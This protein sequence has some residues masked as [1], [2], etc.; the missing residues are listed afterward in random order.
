MLYKF[1]SSS[2]NQTGVSKQT[3]SKCYIWYVLLQMWPEWS[4]SGLTW[5]R[6]E[7]VSTSISL[8]SQ[9]PAGNVCP[10]I[11][12]GKMKKKK[13]KSNG[14]MNTHVCQYL[15]S[16][17]ALSGHLTVELCPLSKAHNKWTQAMH[18]TWCSHIHEYTLGTVP[19]PLNVPVVLFWCWYVWNWVTPPHGSAHC[20]YGVLE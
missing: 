13:K 16:S 4:D 7:K 5:T 11:W 9:V 3:F 10:N 15:H 1:T 14:S 8:A 20:G 12:A 6:V 2:L 19:S 18:N 17:A